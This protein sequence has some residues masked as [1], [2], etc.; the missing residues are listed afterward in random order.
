MSEI[1]YRGADATVGSWLHEDAFFSM[2]KLARYWAKMTSRARHCGRGRA[3]CDISVS[4]LK[5]SISRMRMI[6]AT[7][8]A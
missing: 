7:R 2:G 3:A 1:E 6:D 4:E 5:L 8:M